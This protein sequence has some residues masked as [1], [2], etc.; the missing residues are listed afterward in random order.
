MRGCSVYSPGSIYLANLMG[1]LTQHRR[2]F[3][4]Q[5]EPQAERDW[6]ERQPDCRLKER[7]WKPQEP[8]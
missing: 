4:A 5:T 1:R 2:C 7:D 6:P 8:G 3:G